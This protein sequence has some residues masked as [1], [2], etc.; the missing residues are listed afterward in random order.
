MAYP[1]EFGQVDTADTPSSCPRLQRFS[2]NI[3]LTDEGYKLGDEFHN[4][5]RTINEASAEIAAF[6][7]AMDCITD[8]QCD[9]QVNTTIDICDPFR[10]VCIFQEDLSESDPTKTLT[11]PG[12]YASYL[13][14]YY[15]SFWQVIHAAKALLGFH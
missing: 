1:C 13:Q 4:V 8:D 11:E 2:N 3:T 6:F 5:A 15:L 7:P 10:R 9:D 12:C 14:D